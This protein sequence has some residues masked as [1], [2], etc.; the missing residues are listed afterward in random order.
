MD[1]EGTGRDPDF[2]RERYEGDTQERSW[3]GNVKRTYD[4]YQDLS[5]ESIKRNRTVVDVLLS[6]A[7]ENN[8]ERQKIANQALQN[9][10]TQAN[11]ASV[12]YRRLV[13]IASN[14]QWNVEPAEAAGEA[15]ELRAVTIDDASLKAIGAAVAAAVVDALAKK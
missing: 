7:E 4:E 12:Q 1:G 6:H 3:D 14:K 13:D 8:V 11:E 5:V 15:V 9:A 10:V 2:T